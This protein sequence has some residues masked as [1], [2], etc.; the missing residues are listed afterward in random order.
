MKDVYADGVVGDDE[1]DMSP[2]HEAGR[3]HHHRRG[4]HGIDVAKKED[5]PS[6]AALPPGPSPPWSGERLRFTPRGLC[7]APA[8]PPGL[9]RTLTTSRIVSIV[10][11][12]SITT[13]AWRVA[14]ERDVVGGDM[15][16]GADDGRPE[17]AIAIHRTYTAMH[18]ASQEG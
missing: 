6:S 7:V 14:W 18:R 12:R 15:R 11:G 17:R 2:I 4:A 9:G 10:Q 5:S 3:C 16:R 8:M 1:V 13:R